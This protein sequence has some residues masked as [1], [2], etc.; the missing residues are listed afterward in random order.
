MTSA[1]FASAR[2]AKRGSRESGRAADGARFARNV[3]WRSGR[4]KLAKIELAENG[5]KIKAEHRERM[6]CTLR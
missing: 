3:L 1:R 5:L 2:G 4:L 6:R